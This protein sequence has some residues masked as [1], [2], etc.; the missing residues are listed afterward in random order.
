MEVFWDGDL[1]KTN[2]TISDP[3]SK[4]KYGLSAIGNEWGVLIDDKGKD[5]THVPL[6]FGLN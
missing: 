4:N 3:S 1:N 2:I 5:V 6:S